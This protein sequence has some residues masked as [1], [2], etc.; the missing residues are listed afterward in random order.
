MVPNHI[1]KEV[2]IEA[3]IDVVWQVLTEPDQIT[4]W[5]SQEARLDRRS[6]GAGHLSFPSGQEYFLH[7]ET[8]DPPHRFAYRWLHEDAAHFRSDNSML[9]EFTLRAENGHTRL[10]IVESG[11]DQVDWSDEAKTKYFDDHSRGWAM[12]AE[13]IRAY[14]PGAKV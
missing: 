2:L 11:F 10:R 5:F 3:P 13:R 7:V 14:A 8:F 4:R 6:G 1:E 12:F 9:V